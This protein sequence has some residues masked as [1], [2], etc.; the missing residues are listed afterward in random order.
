MLVG[1]A[2]LT[3]RIAP[4]AVEASRGIRLVLIGGLARSGKSYVSQVLKE[5]LCTFG[6]QAHVISLDGWLKPKPERTEG[7]GVCERFDLAAASALIAAATCSNTR[8]VL[9][10]PIYDRLARTSNKQCIEHSV[11]PG[12][13]LIV[14]G[15]P[16]LLMNGL[17][18]L[19]G[20]MMVFT[21]VAPKTREIRLRQEYDWRGIPPEERLVTLASREIDEVPIVEQSRALANFV[22]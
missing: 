13:V 22:V 11:G 7:S 9:T 20:V 21:D 1:H 18:C 2:D 6:R 17:L 16:A 8:V 19:S 4:L 12:D 14:E 10:E 3:R 15:V 5:L